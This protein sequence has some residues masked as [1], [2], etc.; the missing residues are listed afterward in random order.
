[1]AM[2]EWLGFYVERFDTVELNNSFYKQPTEEAWKLWRETAP[3][4]FTFA[5]KASRFITH[6]KRLKD[7]EGPVERAV[8]GARHLGPHLGPML[9]QL[10]PTFH[11]KDENTRRLEAFVE[12][13]PGGVPHVVEFR[14]ASWFEDET[15]ELLDRWGVGFCAFDMP[16]LKCPVRA[17]GKVGYMRFHGTGERYGGSY[18]D[19]MLRDWAKKLRAMADGR[20]DVFVYFNNDI[21]GHAPRNAMRLREML[22]S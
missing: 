11:R 15:F 9:Y 14:H 22:E 5:V 10:P 2:R 18:S 21:G 12:E 4:G 1:M 19:G 20:D 7:P 17:S 13:L 8:S 16:D 3:E 6:L